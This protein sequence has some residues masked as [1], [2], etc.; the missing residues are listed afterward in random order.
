MTKKIGLK[1]EI[2]LKIRSNK[3]LKIALMDY[4]SILESTLNRWLRTNSSSF[5]EYRALE[6][7]AAYL[8]MEPADLVENSEQAMLVP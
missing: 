6:L 7:I 8:V 3:R 1:E 2:I 4:F 5:T